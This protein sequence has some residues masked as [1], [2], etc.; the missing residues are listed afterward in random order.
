M[1]VM[2]KQI[3]VFALIFA[4][5]PYL[6][7]ADALSLEKRVVEHTCANGIKLL[8]LER[9]FSP[10]VSIRMMFR[11]GS[12]DEVS[13][14]TGLAHMFEH[15]MFKGTRT[16]GTKNYALEAPLLRRI[17]E[18]HRM[19]DLE[20]S[21]GDK[22]DQARVSA[23]LE[24]LRAVEE[25]A[26]SFV[27]E[28]ELWN[29]YEREGGSGVNASTGHDFTRYTVDLPSNKLRLWAVL[30]SDRIRHPVFRQFYSEREVVKEERRMRVDTNS[31]GKL[32]EVF[33]A[34]AYQAHPYRHPTIGWESDL[35]HLTMKDLQD[36]Y[37]KH[38]TPERL[39]I[40]VVGDVKATEV[41]KLVDQY[42]GSWT[43]KP[44][45]LQAVSEEP[46]QTGPRQ[47][48]I[49]FEAQ[50]FVMAGFHVPTFP[51]PDH[52][53]AFALTQI[54][55]S[56]TT[57]RLY[58]TLV[59]KKKIATAVECFGDYPGERFGSLLIVTAT[60][61]HPN[62][63]AIALK[64]IEGELDRLKKEPVAAW[65][66]EKMRAAVEVGILNTLQ[67]NGGMAD[68]LV[69]NQSIFGDWRWLMKFQKRIKEM[70]AQEIQNVARKIFVRENE[71][72]AILE[73]LKK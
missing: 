50:P 19:L 15:M 56:G 66:I 69:Y 68:T 70:T 1:A 2:R 26:A 25:K 9:H 11:T 47:V 13:G 44:R 61:R 4:L 64:T 30:D 29:L 18:L 27:A 65:E 54:L 52:P 62:T 7:A 63:A 14:K 33:L 48:S 60:P 71:T 38:Y 16:L 6:Q 12:V 10:T 42:F 46:P 21:R 59:E 67:T 3:Q 39:T 53:V 37:E 57:S 8:I 17:D 58:K 51:N 24:Q 45:E 49:K 23:L 22:T 32:Y 55:G 40:A 41:I 31:E 35:D 5:I 20:Q 28:N 34:A 43:M 72:V 73:P 36:F